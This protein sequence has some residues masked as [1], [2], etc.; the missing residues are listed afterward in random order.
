MCF[1]SS[2]A[3]SPSSQ[4]A[5]QHV[6]GNTETKPKMPWSVGTPVSVGRQNNLQA[7]LEGSGLGLA[8]HF[9]TAP[10]LVGMLNMGNML[11]A[12]LQAC[13]QFVSNRT[14]RYSTPQ[15]DSSFGSLVA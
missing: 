10:Q 14:S 3:S 6:K 12:S 9:H 8:L 1:R 15:Q 2:Y 5:V 11:I 13:D 7:P 4:E